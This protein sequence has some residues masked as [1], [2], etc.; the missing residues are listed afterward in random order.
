MAHLKIEASRTA[1]LSMDLQA[2]VVKIYTK[3]EPEFLY[4]VRS[5]LSAARNNNIRVIH[6]RVGFRPGL[7]EVDT[8]NQL[9][10]AIK[11]SPQWQQIFQGPAGAIHG[12]VAPNDDEVVITKHRIGAFAG[13]ELDMILRANRIDTLILLGIATSGVVLSTLLHASDADYNL[14]VLRDCCADLDA[15]LRACLTERFFPQRATVI[16]AD[17]LVKALQSTSV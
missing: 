13:T 7:P 6:V 5:A 15:E 16:T 1:L 14:F 10:G 11:N 17:E 3:D 12:D 2:S 4:R 8:R 9:I